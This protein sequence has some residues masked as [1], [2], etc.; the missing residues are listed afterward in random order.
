MQNTS[1]NEQ[2]KISTGSQARPSSSTNQA[3]AIDVETLR[4]KVD[5]LSSKI[6]TREDE[7]SKIESAI[8]SNDA[9]SSTDLEN[10]PELAGNSVADL[11]AAAKEIRSQIDRYK[12]EAE[13]NKLLAELTEYEDYSNKNKDAYQSTLENFAGQTQQMMKEDPEHAGILKQA[14]KYQAQVGKEGMEFWDK[15]A[16]FWNGEIS[17]GSPSP[18]HKQELA[19]LYNEIFATENQINELFGSGKKEDKDRMKNYLSSLQ[20]KVATLRSS[21]EA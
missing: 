14:F 18:E 17:Q 15:E 6:A 9:S 3:S 19:N 20:D 8:G 1:I 13:S 4:S 7:A 11:T 2:I 10:I 16:K 12:E 21:G 5:D